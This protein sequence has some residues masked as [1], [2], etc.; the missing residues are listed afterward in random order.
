MTGDAG[1]AQEVFR[2][3]VREA[4]FLSGRGEPP[5]DPHWFFREARWRCHAV[6]AAEVQ[7]EALQHERAE[8]SSEAGEQV[9]QIEPVQLAAWISATPEP[10]RSAMALFYLNQFTYR[11]IMTILELKLPA[12]VTALDSGRREFQAW[13]N[14][15][16]P[17]E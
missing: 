3:T 10:Q 1:K 6:V 14:A 5:P 7:P 16:V 2:D 13:L 11:E 15:A 8:I 12:L 4:A 9:A 17:A